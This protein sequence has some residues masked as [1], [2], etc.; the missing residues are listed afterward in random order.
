M[1]KKKKTQFKSQTKTVKLTTGVPTRNLQGGFVNANNAARLGRVVGLVN[2]FSEA[3]RG[4][5]LPDDDAT[6]S[7]AIRLTEIGWIGT[8]LNGDAMYDFKAAP[9]GLL[10]SASTITGTTATTWGSWSGFADYTN[11]STSAYQYRIV[12]WGIRFYPIVSPFEASGTVKFITHQ[13]SLNNGQNMA[14]NFWPA[15]EAAGVQ[16]MDVYWVSKP[17]GVTWKQYIGTSSLAPWDQLAVYVTG[18]KVS[19]PIIGFE[20]VM[21]IEAVPDIGA[22]VAGICKPGE[23]HDPAALAAASQVHGSHRGYHRGN[24]IGSFLGRLA[25]QALGNITAGLSNQAVAA[26]KSFF[27]IPA[28][29]PRMLV[30]VD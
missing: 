16:D 8:D 14:T 11:F 21:N 22:A 2:P 7:F 18:A 4:A 10:R 6:A 30:D 5:R 3:S 12:S 19:S 15:V 9:S 1:A 23:P 17:I 27:G 26:A 28:S 20:V 24:S 25:R 29:Y 13:D